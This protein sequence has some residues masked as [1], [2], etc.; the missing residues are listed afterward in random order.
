[1]Q[2]LENERLERLHAWLQDLNRLIAD[3]ELAQDAK[4]LD[5]ARTMLGQCEQ[6]ITEAEQGIRSKKQPQ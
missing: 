4:I 3:A 1:M 6:L 2:D 5:A